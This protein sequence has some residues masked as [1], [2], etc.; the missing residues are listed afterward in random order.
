MYTFD[1]KGTTKGELSKIVFTYDSLLGKYETERYYHE[2]YVTTLKPKGKKSNRKNRLKGSDNTISSKQ[3]EQLF[4]AMNQNMESSELIETIDTLAFQNHVNPKRIKK[5]AK[6][7]DMGWL[8]KRKYSSPSENIAFFCACQ[9][10]DSLKAYL[11]DRF[12]TKGYMIVTDYD[13]SIDLTISTSDG[14]HRFEG[15]YPNPI[16]Q[17]WYDHAN[18]MDRELNTVIN[19]NI[20]WMLLKILPHDFLHLKSIDQK[21]LFDDYIGWFLERKEKV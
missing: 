3:L 21:R 6:Q 4:K 11:Q 19:F 9:S 16:K 17:P 2:K 5:I 20:N 1:Q 12:K 13:H 8:F 18:T 7:M 15:K 14:H 10:L